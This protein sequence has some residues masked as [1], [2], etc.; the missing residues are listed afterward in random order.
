[1][2]ELDLDLLSTVARIEQIDR[3]GAD[4]CGGLILHRLITC[5]APRLYG[6]V[7]KA[8]RDWLEAG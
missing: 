6:H 8:A 2:S 3:E 7:S 5:D 4:T 1:V